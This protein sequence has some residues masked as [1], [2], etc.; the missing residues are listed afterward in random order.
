VQIVT[1]V[2]LSLYL[3][4]RLVNVVSLRKRPNS[5]YLQNKLSP[6]LDALQHLS[7]DN[8]QINMRFP[9][10]CFLG[11]RDPPWSALLPQ[12]RGAPVVI[13]CRRLLSCV[14]SAQ[15]SGAID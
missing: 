14:H 5:L 9:G 12:I 3:G 6:Y 1:R 8:V 4:P 2:P 15:R 13:S 7:R 11:G 10:A